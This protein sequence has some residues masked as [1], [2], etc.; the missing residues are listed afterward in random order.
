[1]RFLLL[2]SLMI[3]IS[4]KVTLDVIKFMYAKFVDWDRD[5]YYA[6]ADLPAKAV[7]TS[8]GEDLGQIEHVFTDKTGTLTENVMRFHKCSIGGQLYPSA[9]SPRD[10]TAIADER[11]REAARQA[12]SLEFEFFRALALCQTAVSREEH[13][14]N[15]VAGSDDAEFLATVS[16]GLPSVS[17]DGEEPVAEAANQ[18]LPQYESSSPDELALLEAASAL[19]IVFTHRE[20]AL[21]RVRLHARRV[22]EYE[23]LAELAF[24]SDRKRMSAVVRARTTGQVWLYCKGAD[25]VMLPLLAQRQTLASRAVTVAQCNH[26]AASGLRTLLIARRQLDDN[27]FAQWKVRH[28]AAAA[29]MQN[30][31]EALAAVYAEL[32]QQL[33]LLGATAIEDKLQDGVPETIQLLRDAGIGVWM[34]TGDKHSTAVQIALSCNLIKL[35]GGMSGGVG[36]SNSTASSPVHSSVALPGDEGDVGGGDGDDPKT[37]E[38]R[39]GLISIEGEDRDTAVESLRMRYGAFKRG[40]LPRGF[41]VIVRG[42]T[43]AHLLAEE[44]LS[45]T[46]AV[47]CLAATTVICCR[48]TPKQKAR[49]VALAK[50]RNRLTLAIGDGGNDVGMIQEAHVGVGIAG[51]E[52]LQAARAAD[53]AVGRFKFLGKLLLVHGRYAYKRTSWIAQYAFYKSMVICVLQIAFGFVSAFS[54]SS[55]FDSTSLTLYNVAFTNFYTMAMVLERDVSPSSAMSVPA[56]YT[57]TQ[58]SKACNRKTFLFWVLRAIYQGT[59]VFISMVLYS[60]EWYIDGRPADHTIAATAAYICLLTLQVLTIIVESHTPTVI[61]YAVMALSYA[62]YWTFLFFVSLILSSVGSWDVVLVVSGMPLFWIIVLLTVVAA[63]L[64]VVSVRAY[65]RLTNPPLYMRVQEIEHLPAHVAKRLLV[66]LSS[67]SYDVAL[68]ESS[69]LLPSLNSKG[70][71][72][73]DFDEQ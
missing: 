70:R 19:G 69:P 8:I 52:G 34:L 61:N 68:S 53:Y 64:P 21:V 11:L 49:I 67:D 10:A 40:D 5:L 28:D 58:A 59:L 47:V 72:T 41:S 22:E 6:D 43:L 66:G 54:G 1:V 63:L 16:G 39:Y 48:V 25:T 26:F 38:A 55:L 57:E 37:L 9:G 44:E 62:G 73:D 32:E 4:L 33:E 27:V 23:W 3:P 35:G 13:R 24:S 31:E 46:L 15:V 2:N 71:A 30:R 50:E 14:S 18:S 12:D 36:G 45:N 51:R 42:S 20:R 56:L 17:R 60:D 65:T 7:S 29:S